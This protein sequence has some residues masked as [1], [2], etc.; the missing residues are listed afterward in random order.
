MTFKDNTYHRCVQDCSM[1]P[2]FHAY[3]STQT[4]VQYCPAPTWAIEN[5]VY[6]SN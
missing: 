4:C 2:T 5:Y 3:N 1:N 6:C